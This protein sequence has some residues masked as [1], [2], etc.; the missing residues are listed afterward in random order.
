MHCRDS[1]LKACPTTIRLGNLNARG[2]M[3]SQ[4]LLYS[5]NIR[6][7]VGHDIY[8][9]YAPN[10]IKGGLRRMNVHQGNV[11]AEHHAGAGGS[12][13]ASHNKVLATTRRVN[14]NS[15]AILE[16]ITIGER[17]R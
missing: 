6:G 8:P 7:R 3:G 4:A 15:V 1:L 17:A 12:K 14:R 9:I 5:I 13:E 11:A 10:P 2:K 16:S